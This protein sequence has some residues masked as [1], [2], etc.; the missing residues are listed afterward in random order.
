MSNATN[1]S[2]LFRWF[3]MPWVFICCYDPMTLNFMI[4]CSMLS[5]QIVLRFRS[6]VRLTNAFC[7]SRELQVG[8]LISYRWHLETHCSHYR[9]AH[10]RLCATE[11]QTLNVA[12]AGLLR[13][14]LKESEE[15]V[16]GIF[17]NLKKDAFV[18]NTSPFKRIKSFIGELNQWVCIHY[19]ISG[20][21]T[22]INSIELFWRLTSIRVTS[23]PLCNSE[24]STLL[25]HAIQQP[26]KT[27][28]LMY[29]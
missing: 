27:S 4:T 28:S 17:W 7:S 29:K 5:M 13:D 1:V 15:H 19:F 2:S 25:L 21:I 20:A 6:T 22:Y 12:P 26:T 24:I 14:A 16:F 9:S 11:Q 10:L 23:D 3:S 18:F 8:V